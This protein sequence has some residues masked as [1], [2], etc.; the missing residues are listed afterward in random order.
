MLLAGKRALDQVAQARV[1]VSLVNRTQNN[2]QVHGEHVRFGS[3]YAKKFMRRSQPFTPAPNRSPRGGYAGADSW[4]SESREGNG[5]R[6]TPGM[7]YYFRSNPGPARDFGFE[8]RSERPI[9][10]APRDSRFGNQ[11]VAALGDYSDYPTRSPPRNRFESEHSRGSRYDP[12]DHNRRE[13]SRNAEPYRRGEQYQRREQSP[14]AEPYRRGEQHQQQQQQQQQQQRKP[15]RDARP[16]AGTTQ[17]YSR[18]TK[19]AL[20]EKP[21]LNEQARVKLIENATRLAVGPTDSVFLKKQISNDSSLCEQILRKFISEDAVVSLAQ[22]KCGVSVLITLLWQGT[23]AQRAALNDTT[24]DLILSLAQTEHGCS[25]VQNA[26]L[27]LEDDERQHV[28]AELL[29]SSESAK[30]LAESQYGAHVLAGL[31]EKGKEEDGQLATELLRGHLVDLALHKHGK[32]VAKAILRTDVLVSSMVNEC[33][34][35]GRSVARLASSKTGSAVLHELAEM[36]FVQPQ[37]L[38][39]FVDSIQGRL[40]EI[41][42][43]EYGAI[44]LRRIAEQFDF[45]LGDLLDEELLQSPEDLMQCLVHPHG[46]QVI[47]ALVTSETRQPHRRDLLIAAAKG[48]LVELSKDVHG[49]VFV[50]SMHDFFPKSQR[51]VLFEEFLS[52]PEALR[53]SALHSEGHFVVEH[54][55]ETGDVDE[56]Q[57]LI[58][59]LFNDDEA[60][61]RLMTHEHGTCVVKTALATLP[62]DE[63]ERI[64]LR[65]DAISAEKAKGASRKVSAT[66][67]KGAS[68]KVSS[69]KANDSSSESSLG[70]RST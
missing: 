21:E 6:R 63:R 65:V 28:V 39:A 60:L 70:Q 46:V 43:T 12:Y 67:A 15:I 51:D 1:L 33:L 8:Q 17:F 41:A 19:R 31:I 68:S 25:Y 9:P 50:R 52:S 62:R 49:S 48:R 42:L 10:R 20:F 5:G 38:E 34:K 54:L 53:E 13:Q 66:K 2:R 61:W 32:T 29:A 7:D 27:A 45:K 58:A 56:R 30:A 4:R 24:A 69:A 18:R 40:R 3:S 14:N 23:A 44:F 55:L 57:K 37:V 47:S 35:S 36:G 26:L 22:H 11:K 64:E 59:G 16:S